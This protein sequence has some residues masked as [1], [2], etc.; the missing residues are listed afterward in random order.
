MEGSKQRTAFYTTNN[1]TNFAID[2]FSNI[3]SYTY[4]EY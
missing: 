1:K 3:T 4:K 2:L